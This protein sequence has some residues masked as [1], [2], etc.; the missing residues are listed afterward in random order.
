VIVGLLEIAV[1]DIPREYSYKPAVFFAGDTGNQTVM[2]PMTSRD[3]ERSNSWLQYAISQ[4][5]LEMVLSN[6]R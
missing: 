5:Q 3:P 4:K 1:V 2:W 6:N